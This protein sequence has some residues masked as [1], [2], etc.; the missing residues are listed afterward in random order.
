VKESLD[1]GKR[2]AKTIEIS[3]A[4]SVQKSS[5]KLRMKFLIYI[6]ALGLKTQQPGQ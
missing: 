5:P 6:K 2:R 1:P 4:K 3:L